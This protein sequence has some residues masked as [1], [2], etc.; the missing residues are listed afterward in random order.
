MVVAR[1]CKPDLSRVA[2]GGRVFWQ[3]KTS[4][5]CV[6]YSALM[7]SVDE[8]QRKEGIRQLRELNAGGI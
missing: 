6:F 2:G 3:M 4:V 5:Y 8:E 7:L 1:R